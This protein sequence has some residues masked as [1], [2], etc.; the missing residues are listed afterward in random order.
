MRVFVAGGTGVI[1]RTLVPLLVAGGHE[2]T[3]MTRSI[4]GDALLRSLG[5][6][7]VMA[8]ALDRDSV[9]E[10]V[11]RTRPEAIIHQLTDLRAGNGAANATLRI[12]GTR[13]LVDAAHAA[14]VG[15]VIARAWRGPTCPGTNLPTS[16]CHW[17]SQR[18]SLGRRRSGVTAL[19]L[20]VREVPQWI[21][22]AT[23]C[24]TV[25]GRGTPRTDCVRTRLEQAAR[26]NEDVT[27]F[28][29]VGDAALAAAQALD[30]P[31]GAVNVC[32]DDPAPGI[33]WVPVF[34]AAVDAPAPPLAALGGRRGREAPTTLARAKSLGGRHASLLA[35]R[36]SVASA[37]AH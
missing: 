21:V 4:E 8:D 35:R 33:E 30:W 2:V 25:R 11:V 5:A 31:S 22:L 15:R 34:C 12:E 3:A 1:G 19:E 18:P 32:D 36:V 9:L 26:R 13:N 27:S 37:H 16:R 17:T 29:H 14:S 6:Q 24:S 28:V 7:P 23:A 10:A 20:A